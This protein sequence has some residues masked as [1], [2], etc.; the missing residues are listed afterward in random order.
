MQRSI[1]DCLQQQQQHPHTHR[2]YTAKPATK[3]EIASTPLLGALSLSILPDSW[4]KNL[5]VETVRS[6]LRLKYFQQTLVFRKLGIMLII[7]DTEEKEF[8][9][10]EFY[11]VS[12]LDIGNQGDFL[13]SLSPFFNLRLGLVYCKSSGKKFLLGS[14]KRASA[15]TFCTWKWQLPKSSCHNKIINIKSQLSYFRKDR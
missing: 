2:L 7:R 1:P 3:N 12:K 10:A 9:A 4:H 6:M 11:H 15:E 13:Q 8:K 14:V 5:S